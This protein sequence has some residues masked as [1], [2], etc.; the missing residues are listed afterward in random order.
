MFVE[1]LP[2][3][4]QTAPSVYY[5]ADNKQL[6]VSGYHTNIMSESE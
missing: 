5:S 6:A 2:P 3:T 4:Y 1:L